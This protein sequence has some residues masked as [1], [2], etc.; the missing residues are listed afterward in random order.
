MRRFRRL[1]L[2][3]SNIAVALQVGASSEAPPRLISS[4]VYETEG[5]GFRIVPGGTSST[6]L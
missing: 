3:P 4:L 6:Q 5:G 2:R 1:A